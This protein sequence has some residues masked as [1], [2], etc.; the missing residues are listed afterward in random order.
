MKE[1]VVEEENISIVGKARNKMYKQHEKKQK[2]CTALRSNITGNVI[3]NKYS[4]WV[5]LSVL[6]AKD[7]LIN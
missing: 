1:N 5:F 4:R 2:Y 3:G 7:E 6:N